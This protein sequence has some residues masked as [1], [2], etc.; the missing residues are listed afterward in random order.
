MAVEKVKRQ[1]GVELAYEYLPGAAPMVVFLPGYASDMGGTKAMH[2]RESCAA[3]GQAM[4][5]LDYSGHGESGGRFE[6]GGIGT[7]A[8]DAMRVIEAVSA[9]AKMLLVGSSMGGWLALLLALRFGAKVES[10]LL[11]A[12]AP[13]FTELMIRPNLTPEH[14]A[15]LARDGM[16]LE[17]SEYGQ[18][19]PITQKLLDEGSKHLLLG[20]KIGIHCPVCVLHGM[21]DPDV[22]W[23]HSL[24]LAE[25][26]QSQAVELIFIKDGDHRLSRDADLSLL[27]GALRRLLG[28]NAP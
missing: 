28:K 17:P 20:E 9:G 10:L 7:W 26:L 23:R 15:A 19:L 11:I 16:F 2:L 22:P 18:K 14:Q 21:H 1:D 3:S 4:L 27:A 6:E 13:D 5:R 12:P 24:K 8:E 25:C